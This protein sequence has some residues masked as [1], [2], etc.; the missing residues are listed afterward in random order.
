[1]PEPVLK[2]IKEAKG[3]VHSIGPNPWWCVPLFIP[4]AS[5]AVCP[6]STIFCS[7]DVTFCLMFAK[8]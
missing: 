1:M 7:D 4:C 2:E 8:V 6:R 5:A 3:K